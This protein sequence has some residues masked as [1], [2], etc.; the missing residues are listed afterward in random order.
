MSDCAVPSIQ[1]TGVAAV[2]VRIRAYNATGKLDTKTNP[3]MTLG[4]RV[5]LTCDVTGISEGSEVVGYRWFHNCRGH[6]TVLCEI[7]DSDPY[8][9]VMKDTLLLDVS[10]LDQEGRYYCTAQCQQETQRAITRE[11]AVAG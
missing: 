11:L 7:Q 5:L 2:T 1:L 8:Y 9:R 3:F 4:T 6:P 10:S